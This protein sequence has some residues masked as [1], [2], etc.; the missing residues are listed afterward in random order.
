MQ[1]RHAGGGRDL[2]GIQEE[3]IPLAKRNPERKSFEGRGKGGMGRKE[4]GSVEGE[5]GGPGWIVPLDFKGLKFP[6]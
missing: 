3:G 4:E 2:L 5:N 1:K 6:M